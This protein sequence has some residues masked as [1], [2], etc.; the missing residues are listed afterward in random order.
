MKVASVRGSRG[1]GWQGCQDPLCQK[2]VSKTSRSSQLAPVILR[3][4][5]IEDRIAEVLLRD[6]ALLIC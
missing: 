3:S 5:K 4:V 1:Y 6:E 2:V